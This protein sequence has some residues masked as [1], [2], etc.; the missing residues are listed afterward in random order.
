MAGDLPRDLKAAVAAMLDGVS[1]KDLAIR[2][3]KLSAHYRAGGSSGTGVSDR[4]DVAAYLVSRMPATFAA[5]AAVFRETERAAPTFAPVSVLDVGAGPGTASWAAAAAWPDIE[6]VTMIDG[7]R[8]FIA[9]AG[10]LAAASGHPA[11][12]NSARV[13]ADATRLSSGLPKA[14]LVVAAYA[15][16]E[17][18]ETA[19]DAFIATLWQASQGVLVL[20]EPGTPAG[21]AR[22]RSARAA[23]IKAGASVAA[24][25]PHALACPIVAPDWC[26]F[27]ERLP[28][29]RDHRLAKS[30]EAPFEDEKF[31]WV[32]VSRPSVALTPYAAR[33]LAP[34]RS[35]KAEIRLKLCTADGAIAERIV[36][37]RDRVAHT[38]FRRTWWGDAILDEV[39]SDC[40][41]SGSG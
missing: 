5:V 23:L 1:R 31:S 9:A 24:P 26:H 28:R 7:S 11:L 30:A 22:I 17:M 33:V 19:A 29:S 15:L 41:A 35:S 18:R 16:A 8:H 32:A 38:R 21:F 20:V 14:N 3:E 4:A 13:F 25:C 39:Q 36:P 6:A 40:H 34:P 12:S 37:L 27:A 2:A 10:E